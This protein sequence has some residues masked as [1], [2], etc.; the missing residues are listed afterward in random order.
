M[1]IVMKRPLSDN[2]ALTKFSKRARAFNS[3]TLL[4]YVTLTSLGDPLIAAMRTGSVMHSLR[5]LKNIIKNDGDYR[6]MVRNTGVAMEN[7]VH[8]RLMYMY[9]GS[10]GNVSNAFFNATLL[11]PWTDMNRQLAGA[12]GYELFRAEQKRAARHYKVGVPLHM[13]SRKYKAAHR[14]MN[15]YGLGEWLPEGSKA[16]ESLD[17][18][19]LSK[20]EDVRIAIIKFTD[21]T[22]FQPNPNEVPI[23]AQTP[24]GAMIFQLKSFPVMMSRLATHAIDEA[25]LQNYAPLMAVL[26]IGPAA[27]AV[28]LT[29]KDHL[30]SRGGED[31]KSAASRI[32]TTDKLEGILDYLGYDKYHHGDKHEFLGWYIE[33]SM[34]MGGLGLLADLFHDAAVQKEHGAYGTLRTVSTILGPTV[35]TLADAVSAGYGASADAKTNA[36]DRSAARTVVGRAPFIGG[37]KYLKESIVDAWAGESESSEGLNSNLNSDINGDL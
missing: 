25:R 11:T 27:G 28:A 20:N 37:N 3:L 36:K 22:I 12:T 19:D 24:V 4:S 35:G 16:N 33:S 9:G 13:Q 32:R 8:E 21:D 7:I 34:L 30:Q 14:V 29:A 2:E 5:A 6:A 23:W 31:E 18:S 26:S 17:L 10:N 15:N 1:K